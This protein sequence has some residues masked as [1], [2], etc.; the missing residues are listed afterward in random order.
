MILNYNFHITCA[1]TL[2]TPQGTFFSTSDKHNNH[3]NS[4]FIKTMDIPG[5]QNNLSEKQNDWKY[6]LGLNLE[7]KKKMNINLKL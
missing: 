3:L 5:S 1:I 2:I 6:Y 4:R 7:G